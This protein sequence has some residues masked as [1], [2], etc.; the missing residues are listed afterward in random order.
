MTNYSRGDDMTKKL[1][2][3]IVERDIRQNEL[4]KRVGISTTAMNAVVNG[5]SVPSL[6]T[7]IRIAREVGSTVEEL[8]GDDG[9]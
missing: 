4:A 3:L 7:A 8:W 6:H 5:K 1:K 2:L 9:E